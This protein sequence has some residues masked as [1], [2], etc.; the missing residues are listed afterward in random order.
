MRINKAK[1]LK[2]IYWIAYQKL[3]KYRRCRY[4]YLRTDIVIFACVVKLVFGKGT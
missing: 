2:A 1:K 3:K 4:F